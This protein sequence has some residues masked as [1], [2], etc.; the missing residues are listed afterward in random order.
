[1]NTRAPHFYNWEVEYLDVK[2]P[3]WALPGETAVC[4]PSE[5]KT[6]GPRATTAWTERVLFC[7]LLR[8]QRENLGYFPS[9]NQRFLLRGNILELFHL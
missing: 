9:L 3:S 5:P 6:E 1:M 8:T 7:V 4:L 2:V